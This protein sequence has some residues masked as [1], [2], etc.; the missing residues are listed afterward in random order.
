M[1]NQDQEQQLIERWIEP[2]PWKRGVEEARLIDSKVS[3]WA[4]MGYLRMVG[5]DLA[6]RQD[7][8]QPGDAGRGDGGLPQ[9]EV[10]QVL[11]AG[12]VGQS[13]VAD[14]AARVERVLGDHA[15]VCKSL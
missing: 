15:G 6:L 1:G 5:G 3:I 10:T 11:Q 9:V 8:P 14:A 12:Q 4:L 7:L 13:R 2:H